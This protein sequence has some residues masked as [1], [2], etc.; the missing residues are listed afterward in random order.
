MVNILLSITDLIDTRSVVILILIC[1]C[2]IVGPT[3]Y[4]HEKGVEAT[5]ICFGLQTWVLP[6]RRNEEEIFT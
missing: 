6:S 1:S 3:R 4:K 2:W 5:L